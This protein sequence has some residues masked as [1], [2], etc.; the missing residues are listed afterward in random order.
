M[1]LTQVIANEKIYSRL[2]SD[3]TLTTAIKGQG[4]MAHLKVC[5]SGL[6]ATGLTTISVILAKN[7]H[8][9]YASAS[10]AILDATQQEHGCAERSPDSYAQYFWSTRKAQSLYWELFDKRAANLSTDQAIDK[11]LLTEL[12][13]PRNSLIESLTSSLLVP[14]GNP[15]F[16]IHF[17]APLSERVRRVSLQLP[18]MPLG[19]LTKMV[20]SKDWRTRTIVLRAWNVDILEPISRPSYDLVITDSGFSKIF[21]SI[22]NR[23]REVAAKAEVCSAFIEMYSNVVS[24]TTDVVAFHKAA[25]RC[26]QALICFGP[27]VQV[28]P[29]SFLHPEQA[30]RLIWSC[31]HG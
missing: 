18:M 6:T 21:G 12:D 7:L 15:A 26:R 31:R 28:F 11:A 5:T 17:R 30:M 8:L 22:R 23:D 14:P 24:K 25:N 16:H 4:T 20:R 9:F 19:K 10:N 29:Q 1:T 27:V 2:A 13:V 3:G